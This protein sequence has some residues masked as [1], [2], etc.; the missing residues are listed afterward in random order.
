MIEMIAQSFCPKKAPKLLKKYPKTW[1]IPTAPKNTR[2]AL[3][4]LLWHRLLCISA[5]MLNPNVKG[6]LLRATAKK[7]ATRLQALD[8]AYHR[9]Q[10][11]PWRCDYRP[12]RPCRERPSASIPRPLA[13]KN[14]EI[15]I[16][17]SL[18]LLYL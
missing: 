5:L 1:L 3:P 18:K 2:C 17:F 12:L 13:C 8:S 14:Y 4:L 7:P 9:E 10:T 15:I 16:A 11:S 6:W